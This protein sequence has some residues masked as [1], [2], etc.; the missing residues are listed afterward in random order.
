[1][2]S[3]P[4]MDYINSLVMGAQHRD[5]GLALPSLLLVPSLGELVSQFKQDVHYVLAADDG[6]RPSREDD[7]ALGGRRDAKADPQQLLVAGDAV[8]V[9]GLDFLGAQEDS[10]E[11]PSPRRGA[12][13]LS[14][15]LCPPGVQ[16]IKVEA[17]E[18]HSLNLDGFASESPLLHENSKDVALSTINQDPSMLLEDLTKHST[19]FEE[20]ADMT[21]LFVTP[22]G[23]QNASNS[24]VAQ[25]DGKENKKLKS[26]RPASPPAKEDK[27]C[28]AP[29]EPEPSR[30]K[31]EPQAV[32]E[33]KLKITA[34][35]Q[36]AHSLNLDVLPVD[37]V[38]LGNFLL[39]PDAMSPVKFQ[40]SHGVT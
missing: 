16:F 26:R 3:P 23:E 7:E 1:M 17:Y 22:L 18:D 20:A 28:S 36:L 31:P 19:A 40:V 11:W 39:V 2:Q 30:D 33:G 37:S 32:L 35:N 14:A 6:R 10:G 29:D 21:D 8:K 25:P 12:R 15:A 9:S 5:G 13:A 24:L 34:S 27:C 38:I 4:A